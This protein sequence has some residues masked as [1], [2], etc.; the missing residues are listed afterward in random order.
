[1]SDPESPAPPPFPE[2]GQA[3][4]PLDKP[5]ALRATLRP[6]FRRPLFIGIGAAAALLIALLLFLSPWFP[7]RHPE[8]EQAVT[9]TIAPG[10]SLSDA[11]DKLEAAGVISSGGRFTLLA[12]LLGS[13]D[14]IQ[15]GEFAFYPGDGWSQ[16]LETL[17][18]G[19]SIRRRIVI[20]EG[21]PSVLV[22][23]RLTAAPLMEGEVAIPAEGSILPATYDYRRGMARADLLAQMQAAMRA[24]LARLWPQ[25]SAAAVVRT[26]EEAI[27]LASIVEKE[28]GKPEEQRLIAGVY[29]NRLR[30]NIPLQADPTVIYPVTRGRPLGR[31][32]LRSELQDRGNAYNTYVRPG[33]PVGP[34]TNPGR[35]SIAAV[36]NPE[37]TDFL[38]FVADGTGGH[39]FART[40]AE[41]EANVAR[42]YALQ[43]ERGE[44]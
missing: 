4:P 24:E 29:S 39:V 10:D 28:T 6:W 14:G 22:Q 9:V 13:G 41:H 11:A 33:L 2:L 16:Q 40:L 7:H 5:I 37:A 31:R 32:I 26:P 42:Y 25:R 43:R 34:I 23:E 30:Q 20:P 38:Y 36:L 15:A 35:A 18:N 21:L 17:Q 44:R 27:I 19:G 3:P 1:M 12:R 8:G